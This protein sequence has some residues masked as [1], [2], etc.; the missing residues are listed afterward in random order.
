MCMVR[1]GAGST[2]CIEAMSAP[3][4]YPCLWGKVSANGQLFG[5]NKG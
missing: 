1:S 2:G 5:G 4:E 3:F